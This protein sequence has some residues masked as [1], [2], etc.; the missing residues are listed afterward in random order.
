MFYQN[1][2]REVSAA[3]HTPATRFQRAELALRWFE[4]DKMWNGKV[5]RVERGPRLRRPAQLPLQPT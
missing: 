2:I 5:E 4:A 1:P 3:L